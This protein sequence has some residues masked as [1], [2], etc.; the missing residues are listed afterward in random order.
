MKEQS[1]AKEVP[2]LHVPAGATGEDLARRRAWNWRTPMAK[3]DQKPMTEEERKEKV[4][5]YNRR[6]AAK[7][8]ALAAGAPVRRSG[9]REREPGEAGSR[10]EPSVAVSVGGVRITATSDAGTILLRIEGAA[11]G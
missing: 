2:V 7:R 5:A 11:R 4:R 3:K 8:K 6:Y 9:E 10:A 1:T